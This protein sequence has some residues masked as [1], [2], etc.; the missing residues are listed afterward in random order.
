MARGTGIRGVYASAS[1]K[2][3]QDVILA[4]RPPRIRG[5]YASASLKPGGERAHINH[6]ASHPRCLR[7]G[8][9]EASMNRCGISLC[10]G[11]SEVFTPRPH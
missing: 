1:L 10:L 9:I 2:H 8:L 5:V 3:L 11:A 4:R 7:L 6:D